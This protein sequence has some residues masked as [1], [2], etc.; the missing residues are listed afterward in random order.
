MNEEEARSVLEAHLDQWRRRSHADLSTTL[1]NQ[2]CS[3]VIGT[4]GAE[5]QIEIDIM[6]DRKPGP[7][8]RVV[9]AIDDG[10]SWRAFSPLTQSFIMSPDGSIR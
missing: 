9:G 6:W 3:E 10:R 7:E 1:G 2:G 4:S 8:L 5:Y